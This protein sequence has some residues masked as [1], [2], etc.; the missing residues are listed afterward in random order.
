ME[1]RA[2]LDGSISKKKPA[3]LEGQ[4]AV[5][6]IEKALFRRLL[7]RWSVGFLESGFA[8]NSAGHIWF[9][10]DLP[11]HSLV[12]LDVVPVQR[13]RSVSIELHTGLGITCHGAYQRGFR[14]RQVA[15]ILQDSQIG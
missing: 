1:K 15:F 7:L 12:Y 10:V 11:R 2:P 6:T 14:L 3:S 9:C 8:G 13:L 4:P 5:F